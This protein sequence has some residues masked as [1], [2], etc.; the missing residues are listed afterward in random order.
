MFHNN[1]EN[2]GKMDMGKNLGNFIAE[3]E[4]IRREFMEKVGPMSAK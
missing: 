2:T 4:K 1:N 3:E